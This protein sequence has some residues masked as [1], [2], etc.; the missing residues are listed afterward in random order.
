MTSTH[1]RSYR[2]TLYW[3]ITIIAII[4]IAIGLGGIV[5]ASA[6]VNPGTINVTKT[7]MGGSTV[8]QNVR[9]TSKVDY[10]SST[11][12]GNK[13]P[14]GKYYIASGHFVRFLIA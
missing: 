4:S 14:D 11:T 10:G 5:F 9:K 8:L 2:N 12:I 1:T 3:I 13:G 7:E 6:P